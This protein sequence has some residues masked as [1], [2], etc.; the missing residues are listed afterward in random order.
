MLLISHHVQL[1][2]DTAQFLSN[3]VKTPCTFT[4]CKTSERH[5]YCYTD[6][7]YAVVVV[8]VFHTLSIDKVNI[9]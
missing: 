5:P 6:K 4:L 2:P 7:E 1:V 8:F 9:S 3:A